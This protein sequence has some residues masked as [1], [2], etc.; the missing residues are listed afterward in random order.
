MIEK[1]Y[2]D[3]I[4]KLEREIE[5]LK[6][7][8]KNSQKENECK[9]WRA[10]PKEDYWFVELNGCIYDD[11]ENCEGQDNFKY[12]IGNYFRTQQEAQEYK[13]NL[14]TKQKLK[15][16][17]LR[18][19]KGVEID[20]KDIDQYKYSIVF[21]NM[22]DSLYRIANNNDIKIG[23]IYCLDKN[24]LDIAKQEIGEEALIELIKSGV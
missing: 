8:A 3:R 5:K 6:E 22:C 7:E 19:N 20:W 18:L 16:L 12:T 4:E 1:E 11:Y 13:E 24:F 15:D 21:D 17:A 14:I 10:K 2:L 9:R 23:N